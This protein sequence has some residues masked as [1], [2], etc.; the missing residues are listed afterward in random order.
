MTDFCQR[1]GSIEHL[2]LSGNSVTSD[3]FCKL[4]VEDAV[5]SMESK[6][7]GPYRAIKAVYNKL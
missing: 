2:V 5:R 6:F 7:W 4:T 3:T 1:E